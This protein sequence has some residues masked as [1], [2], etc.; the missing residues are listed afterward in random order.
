VNR[1]GQRRRNALRSSLAEI[2]GDYRKLRRV[3]ASATTP[4]EIPGFFEGQ[5]KRNDG[6]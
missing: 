5:D 2:E 3:I 4:A 1:I 6:V